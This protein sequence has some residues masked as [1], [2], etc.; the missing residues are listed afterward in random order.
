VP[1]VITLRRTKDGI[2]WTVRKTIP[3]MDLTALAATAGLWQAYLAMFGDPD[4]AAVAADQTPKSE[5]HESKAEGGKP[6]PAPPKRVPP[7]SKP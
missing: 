6:M 4:A 7:P 5:I 2:E 1:D 3:G